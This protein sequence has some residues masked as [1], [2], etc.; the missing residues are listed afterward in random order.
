M[1]NTPPGDVIV[2]ELPGC[3]TAGN[4]ACAVFTAGPLPPIEQNLVIDG[5]GVAIVNGAAGATAPA[6]HRVFFVDTG[7][8]AIR[9]ITIANALARGGNG[10]DGAN[11]AGGGC[12]G[13]SGSVRQ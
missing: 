7:D 11:A 12:G 3:T 6:N 8:V 9:D 1:S 10:G 2:F 13:R 4:A 5:G